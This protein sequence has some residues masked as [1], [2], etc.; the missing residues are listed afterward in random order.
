MGEIL[1]DSLYCQ[2]IIIIISVIII[3]LKIE[4]KQV[5]VNAILGENKV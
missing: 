1:I 3:I 2:H 5:H 4:M